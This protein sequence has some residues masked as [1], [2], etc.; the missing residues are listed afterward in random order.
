L[1]APD[2]VVAA[3]RTLNVGG[4]PSEVFAS[5]RVLERRAAHF[6]FSYVYLD[7]LPLFRLDVAVRKEAGDGFLVFPLGRL[8]SASVTDQE[9]L[10]LRALRWGKDTTTAKQQDSYDIEVTI[11]RVK[12]R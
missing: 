5:Q 2:V 1:G 4:S 6:G 12:F 3:I 7:D 9:S 8:V 10:C 11:P